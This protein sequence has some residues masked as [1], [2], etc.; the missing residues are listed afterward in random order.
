M[1][2]LLVVIPPVQT[3]DHILDVKVGG[4]GTL[5][6]SLGLTFP[7]GC[8]EMLQICNGEEQK[9][10]QTANYGEQLAS[11]PQPAGHGLL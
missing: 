1:L 7:I 8:K 6:Q 2:D 11:S 9:A 4:N 5:H 3:I 10:G